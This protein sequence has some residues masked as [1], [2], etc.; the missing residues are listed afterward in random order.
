MSLKYGGSVGS[1]KKAMDE[2]RSQCGSVARY[3]TAILSKS[4]TIAGMF[5]GSMRKLRWPAPS[6]Y[7]RDKALQRRQSCG[8]AYS[9][10]KHTSRWSGSRLVEAQSRQRQR[11]F[12]LST[13]E[14]L[15]TVGSALLT[16]QSNCM[17]WSQQTKIREGNTPDSTSTDV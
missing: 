8:T 6:A 2:S 11:A 13:R 5:C 1:R 14:A 4:Q 16:G 15:T 10:T 17:G 9:R 3:E 7:G 12:A